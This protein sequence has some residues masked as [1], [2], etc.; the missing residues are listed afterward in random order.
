MAKKG[1]N[2][3]L[4]A[5]I[6]YT[7]FE[8]K[9]I[10]WQEEKGQKQ[11]DQPQATL[12]HVLLRYISFANDSAAKLTDEEKVHVYEAGRIIG[13]A[14]GEF[15]LTQQQYDV[16]KKIVDNGKVKTPQ[17]QESDLLSLVIHQ[18]TKEVINNAK[19]V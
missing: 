11:E 15:E 1:K 19:V 2:K 18:H 4:D 13:M 14:G 3:E 17:G 12:K 6:K 7:N 10:K 5:R 9:P 16:V 8:G